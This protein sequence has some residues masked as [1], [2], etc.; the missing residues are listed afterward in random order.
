MKYTII[1]HASCT[2]NNYYHETAILKTD[3][4][5]IVKN[6]MNNITASNFNPDIITGISNT[7]SIYNSFLPNDSDIIY[8]SVNVIRELSEYSFQLILEKFNISIYRM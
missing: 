3:Y 5:S 4:L 6:F 2:D 7:Y 1:Q 8:L